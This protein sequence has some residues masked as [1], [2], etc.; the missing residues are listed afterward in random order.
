VAELHPATIAAVDRYWADFFGVEPALLN[1]AATTIVPH[2]GLGDYQGVFCFR[3]GDAL[4]ISVPA[5]RLERDRAALAGLSPTVLDD[6]SA[7]LAKID[8]P[9]ERLVGPAFVGYADAATL[10]PRSQSHVR[11]LTAEDRER[12]ARFRRSCSALD[13]EHGGSDLDA[14]PVVG[15]VVGDEIVAAAG[16]ELWGEQIAHIAVVTQPA[17]RGQGYGGTVVGG[18][19]ALALELGLIP[20]Y[21][22]LLGNRPSIGIAAALGFVGYAETLA[23]RLRAT[24]GAA[25]AAAHS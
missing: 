24:G 4:L 1:R 15:C 20:Q 13:W 6:P 5:A 9:I 23:L 2:A 3:R 11:L 25:G 10:Q 19:A 14:Q 18:I 22:T 17:Q 16:W 8:A 12:F 7:L 21:R